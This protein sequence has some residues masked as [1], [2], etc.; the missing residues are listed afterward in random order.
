MS[1]GLCQHSRQEPKDEIHWQVVL[2]HV[3][4]NRPAICLGITRRGTME[5]G[6]WVAASDNNHSCFCSVTEC[7]PYSAFAGPQVYDAKVVCHLQVVF[8]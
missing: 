2:D 3:L 1:E 4:L 5:V 7:S 8:C 6:G